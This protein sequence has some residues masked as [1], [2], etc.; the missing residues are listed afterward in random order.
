M[1]LFELHR[2]VAYHGTSSEKS[3]KILKSGFDMSMIGSKSGTKLS[4]VSLTIDKHNAREHAEWAVEKFGGSPVILAVNLSNL[5]IMPGTTIT[6][7]W[8][9]HGSLD[10]ALRIARKTVDGAELFDME[11]ESG[12]EELEILIFDPKKLKGIHEI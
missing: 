7:L 11:D 2:A 12:T 8:K 3:D 9:E 10:A 1:K 5:N 4:G 6:K